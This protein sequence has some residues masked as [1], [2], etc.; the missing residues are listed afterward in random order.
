MSG[1]PASLRSMPSP[2]SMQSTPAG[3]PGVALRRRYAKLCELEDFRDP[4][5][6]RWI[7]EVVPDEV[8]EERPRRKAWEFAMVAAFLDEVGALRDDSRV[9]DVAA[10]KEVLV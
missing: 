4:E 10:G 3:P 2:P 1:R 9:L 5:I 7:H 8:P 6:L